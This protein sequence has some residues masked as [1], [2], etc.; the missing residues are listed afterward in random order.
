MP[1]WPAEGLVFNDC[2]TFTSFSSSIR[3][4]LNFDEIT[5]EDSSKIFTNNPSQIVEFGEQSKRVTVYF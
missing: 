1:S 3:L 4:K 5:L 2:N